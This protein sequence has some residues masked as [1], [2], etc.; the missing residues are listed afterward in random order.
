MAAHT[1]FPAAA[2]VVEQTE[3]RV[4]EVVAEP[5]AYLVVEVAV[6]VAGLL[7]V[8]VVALAA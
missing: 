1:V 6:T 4:A 2:A 8:A 7:Q 3:C 5:T